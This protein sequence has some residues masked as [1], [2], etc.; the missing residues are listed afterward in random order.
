ML[1]TSGDMQTAIAELNKLAP[2][3]VVGYAPAHRQKAIMFFRA[4]EANNDRSVLPRLY[5]HLRQGARDE[6]LE[7]DR[8]WI[9][10]HL[11]VGQTEEAIQRLTSAAEKDPDLWIEAA[12]LCSRVGGREESF[13]RFLKRSEIHASQTIKD[14]PLDFQRRLLL[15]RVLVNRNDLDAAGKTLDEGL[16]LKAEPTLLRAASDLWFLRMSRM[17]HGTDWPR[18]LG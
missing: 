8:M 2:D 17:D 14:Q 16:K 7:S 4:F 11:A 3:D 9:A 13:D 5:W 15:T 12:A 10:Y 18:A 1:A 6:S